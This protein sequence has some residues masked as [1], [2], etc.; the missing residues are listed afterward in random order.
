MRDEEEAR[1]ALDDVAWGLMSAEEARP[2]IMAYL[3]DGQASRHEVPVA[4]R[5]ARVYT[6]LRAWTWKALNE[7]RRDD[8]LRG[9]YD[10]M[11]G[12][13]VYLRDGAADF[14]GKLDVL[15]D[16]IHESVWA[17]TYFPEVSERH[18]RILAAIDGGADDV[19]KIA[20]VT[21][22]KP[23]FLTGALNVVVTMALAERTRGE[24]I[25]YAL[26]AA[27]AKAIATAAPLAV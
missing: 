12:L 2:A 25:T 27:G 22:I 5:L 15:C 21:G 7:R 11:K 23:D 19:D 20:A 14:S 6:T 18:V 16:L 1:R 26:T 4:I 24:T 17:S 9:W 8:G 13:S 3:W 10:L